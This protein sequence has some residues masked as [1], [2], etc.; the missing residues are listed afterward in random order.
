MAAAIPRH[1]LETLT[2]CPACAQR[3]IDPRVLPSCGHTVCQPCLEQEWQQ[4][5]DSSLNGGNTNEHINGGSIVTHQ[6]PV[7]TC[8]KPIISV[9]NID[10][11]P[12]NQTVLHLVQSSNFY[13]EANG[14]CE[15]CHQSPSFVKC[16]HCSSLVC[17]DCGHRHRRDATMSLEKELEQ[18][19]QTHYEMSEMVFGTRDSFARRR[20]ELIDDIRKYYANLIN[21][22]KCAQLETE[23]NFTKQ[24]MSNMTTIEQLVDHH[25]QE[26]DHIQKHIHELRAFISDWSTIEQFKQVRSKLKQI[27]DEMNEANR[28]FNKEMPD[29]TLDL[30]YMHKLKT[31]NSEQKIQSPSQTQE[32]TDKHFNS[33]NID[34][35][36]NIVTASSGSSTINETKPVSTPTITRSKPH[37][38]H[39]T[40][41]NSIANIPTTTSNG[42]SIVTN[43]TG[44]QAHFHNTHHIPNNLTTTTSNLPKTISN[45]VA[46]LTLS[47]SSS[48]NSSLLNHKSSINSKTNNFLSKLDNCSTEAYKKIPLSQSFEWGILA[49]TNTDL[50]LLYNKDKSSLVI[51]DSNGHENERIQW[52]EGDIKDLCIYH[53]DSIVVIGEHKIPSKPVECKL[54]LC[55]L[56][57]K[58][59]ER[60][61]IVERGLNCQRCASDEQM[62]YYGSEKGCNKSKISVFD[63]DLQLTVTFE[64]GVEIRS[65]AVDKLFCFILGKRREREPGR[66]MVEKRQKTGQLIRRVDLYE[67]NADNMNRLIVDGYGG[68]IVTDGGNKKVWAV[69][70]SGEKKCV[71]YRP[72]P[73]SIGFL[74]NETLLILHAG[75]LTFHVNNKPNV[76]SITPIQSPSMSTRQISVSNDKL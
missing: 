15:V 5:H 14:Q 37:N 23:Q 53:D 7:P 34:D 35:V 70:A 8:Q 59:L 74:T 18:L 55:N 51:F 46:D 20:D 4:H 3:Y 65:I 16:S 40:S 72:W 10:D 11:L 54:Y 32:V 21:E 2:N 56:N 66:Y 61:R 52:S 71:Q 64:A 6:C 47:S 29:L 19:E 28:L 45:S 36:S 9:K 13:V 60:D 76:N 69:G 12:I 24:Y 58:Q 49:V 17:F 31:Y 73:W 38:G 39:Y 22:M 41:L 48:N 50:I 43:T 68:I 33:S 44:S 57:R 27:K 30:N 63:N 42:L 67:L 25:K 26:I 1:L 62:I 75:C